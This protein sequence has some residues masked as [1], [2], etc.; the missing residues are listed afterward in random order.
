MKKSANKIILVENWISKVDS[1]NQHCEVRAEQLQEGSWECKIKLSLINKT[2]IAKSSKEVNAMLMAAEKASKLIDEYMKEH[3]ELTI[4][5]IYEGKPYF[6][7]SDGSGRFVNIGFSSKYR[8]KEG[9]RMM[10]GMMASMNAIQK[11]IENI[12]E[13]YGTDNGTFIQV[14]DMDW[15]DDMS[16]EDI[17]DKIYNVLSKEYS[18]YFD[19]STMTLIGR[20][21]IVI[22]CA[23]KI[24]FMTRKEAEQLC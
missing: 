9:E 20:H 4:E 11:A 17:R 8:R 21:I 16:Q 7:E 3:P 14:L 5:N 1:S 13:T 6:I 15:F 23:N 18:I 24:E 19:I 2:I 10:G 12:E 22:G